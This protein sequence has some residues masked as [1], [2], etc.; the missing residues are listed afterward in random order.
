[1]F[2]IYFFSTFKRYY[3]LSLKYKD[4]LKLIFSWSMYVLIY[5]V[6]VINYTWSTLLSKSIKTSCAVT[7]YR[8]VMI[9]G[10]APLPL[11]VYLSVPVRWHHHSRPMTITSTTSP[12]CSS[13]YCSVLGGNISSPLALLML[14][15]R[16]LIWFPVGGE[17][18]KE[19]E[20]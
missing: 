4:L 7:Y 12:L 6:F 20:R 10:H 9:C 5:F 14:I 18:D 3:I 15:S 8:I 2:Y 1:M 17:R 16:L 19:W 13:T 11:P